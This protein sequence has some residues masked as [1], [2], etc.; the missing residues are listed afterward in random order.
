MKAPDKQGADNQQRT[1]NGT[2]RDLRFHVPLQSAS[3][4]RRFGAYH[5]QN[6][7]ARQNPLTTSSCQQIKS[8]ELPLKRSKGEFEKP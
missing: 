3:D 1:N 5:R 6:R 2:D 8:S 4:G 7:T